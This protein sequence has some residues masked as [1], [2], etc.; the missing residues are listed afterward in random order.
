M[1]NIESKL[2]QDP[3]AK[4]GDFKYGVNLK[5]EERDDEIEDEDPVIFVK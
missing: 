5:D 2:N 1:D 3:A 4:R